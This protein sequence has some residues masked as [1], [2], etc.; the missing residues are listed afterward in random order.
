MNWSIPA[1]IRFVDR[2]NNGKTDRFYASDVGGN[3]WRVDLE[4]TTGNTPDKWQVTKLAALGCSTGTCASGTT[5]RKF[6]FPPNVVLVGATSVSGSYDAVM[7]GS[8][9]REHP[10]KRTNIDGTIVSGSSY[11]VTNRFYVLKDTKTG[12]DANYPSASSPMTEASLFNATST[13]YNGTLSGFYTTFATGEKSVNESVTVRGTT[14]FGTNRPTPPSTTSCNANLGE[15]KGYALDPFKGAFEATIF[16][17]GGLPP[18]PT[19][20]IVTI[21]I[22][23]ANPGDPPTSVKRSFCVGC[24]GSDGGGDS[25]SAL[26]AGD[27]SKPVPKNTR[28]TYWYKK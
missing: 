21:L 6:F 15:S 19:V 14:F 26:G 9:D 8:G 28:R 2:D 24:G 3:V 7:L 11:G 1:D 4:P 22:P 12:K 5:P 18:T 16:D 17:G 27:L 23:P 13:L 10:L 25:K 20:G